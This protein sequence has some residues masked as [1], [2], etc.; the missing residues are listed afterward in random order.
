MKARETQHLRFSGKSIHSNA[1]M[2][3]VEIES[4]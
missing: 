1:E 4:L 2:S 3:N